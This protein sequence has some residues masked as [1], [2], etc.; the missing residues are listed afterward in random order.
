MTK[1]IEKWWDEAS[2][3]Y[4]GD[5]DIGT[6][7]AHYG[8]YAPNENKLRL[9]GNVKGKEILEIGCGGGQCSIAFSK[10]GAICTGLDLSKEQL[11]YAEKLAK[12]NNVFV[13]FLKHDIQSLKGFESNNYDIV[14]SAFA[15]HY[16]PDLTKCFKEVFRVLKNK[17]IFV[18]SFDHPFYSAIN[19]ETFKV[20]KNYNK[21][22]LYSEK[23]LWADSS[24]HKFVA[25]A[26][27]IS[28]I[29][30]SLIQ[31]GFLI[32]KMIESFDEKTEK[33]WRKGNW[34]KIY[35]IKLVEMIPP[36]IIFKARKGK[37]L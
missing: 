1:E 8:P 3:G 36:T 25:Y 5:S 19:P 37:W 22:G 9:L 34:E 32:E 31:S 14:F 20:D 11:K 26:R 13:K 6:D 12:K 24:E 28:E 18:F 30:D 23:V 17:G 7:S 27:K 35:P 10:Q 4:Q 2:R 21:S 15:L 29:F 33:A 16:V